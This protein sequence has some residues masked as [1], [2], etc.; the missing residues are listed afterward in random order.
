MPSPRRPLSPTSPA[1]WVLLVVCLWLVGPQSFA[2]GSVLPGP[3][4]TVSPKGKD[5]AKG[6]DGTTSV[7]GTDESSGPIANPGGGSSRGP[8]ATGSLALGAGL[9]NRGDLED[10]I[11]WWEF[12]REEVDLFGERWREPST[13]TRDVV[14]ELLP[15]LDPATPSAPL[16]ATILAVSKASQVVTSPHRDDVRR[17]LVALLAHDD[18]RVVETAL[19][20]LGFVRGSEPLLLLA[21]FVGATSRALEHVAKGRREIRSRER[22]FAAVALGL[23]AATETNTDLRRFAVHH[24]AGTFEREHESDVDLAVACLSAIGQLPLSLE[25]LTQDPD[26]RGRRPASAGGEAQLERLLA[27][28]DKLRLDRRLKPHLATALAALVAEQPDLDRD[29]RASVLGY[30]TKELDQ[31]RDTSRRRAAALALGWVTNAGDSP[32]DQHARQRLEKAATTA[33]D[34]WTKGLATM[35]WVEASTRADTPGASIDTEQLV[36]KLIRRTERARG[37]ERAWTQLALGWCGARLRRSGWMTPAALERALT[38]RLEDA[39]SPLDRAS[40]AAASGMAEVTSARSILT[41]WLQESSLPEVRASA[42]LA[43]GLCDDES[44]EELLLQVLEDAGHQPR[45]QREVAIA[46]SRVAP[47]RSAQPLLEGLERAQSLMSRGNLARAL[48]E[49]RDARSVRALVGLLGD[50]EAPPM[51]RAY[52]GAALGRLVD[53]LP[54]SWRSR[55]FGRT[56]YFSTPGVL[57]DESGNGVLN[58]L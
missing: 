32:A 31:K 33:G 50:V 35:S 5:G 12:R 21:E 17:A 55:L 18:P 37:P 53:P 24:L 13:L 16:R 56:A 4:D 40:L 48:G 23:A 30:L 36:S 8:E 44:A 45:I 46:L 19:L 41:E 47:S 54:R 9:A 15:L 27:L 22:S 20:G 3:G 39:K 28:G 42:A 49:V 7:T 51:V 2:Q 34:T 25:G 57:Y 58:L 6:G 38:D 10:W 29:L 14:P 26:R 43:L 52:A 1:S 11:W